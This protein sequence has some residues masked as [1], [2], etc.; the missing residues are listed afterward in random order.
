[1]KIESRKRYFLMK[2]L[3][4]HLNIPTEKLQEYNSAVKLV[5]I[6]MEL[7]QASGEAKK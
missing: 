4:F 6:I 1:M 3:T 7:A 5:N 2:R